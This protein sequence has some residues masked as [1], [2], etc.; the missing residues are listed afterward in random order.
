[1]HEENP[2]LAKVLSHINAVLGAQQRPLL[3]LGDRT[4]G[5]GTHYG[6]YEEG[7]YGHTLCPPRNPRECG[8]WL[9]GFLAAIRHTGPAVPEDAKADAYY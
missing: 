2:S 9:D 7:R 8:I 3:V 6:V 1:M 5:N 4:Y